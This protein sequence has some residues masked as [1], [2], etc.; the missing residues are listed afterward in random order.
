MTKVAE[1]SLTDYVDRIRR[2]AETARSEAKLEGEFNQVLKECLAEFGVAFDPHVNETLRGLGLS[3]VDTDRPDGV[4]G[5]I[6]YDYKAPGKLS[7]AADLQK[8]KDQIEKKYLDKITGGHEASPAAC[9][10][11]SATCATAFP[12]STA[13]P[14]A[15]AGNGRGDCP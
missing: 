14:T 7:N 11:G 9:A 8:A 1:L 6:V 2:I 4:F 5:H 10:T 13:G 3:Q 15:W 12:S